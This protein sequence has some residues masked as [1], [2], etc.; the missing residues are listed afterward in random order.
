MFWYKKVR[1]IKQMCDIHAEGLLVGAC[2]QDWALLSNFP[3]KFQQVF[4]SYLGITTST[5]G[6]HQIPYIILILSMG[7]TSA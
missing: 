1:G 3:V 2:N 5:R 4:Y 6:Q 7:T